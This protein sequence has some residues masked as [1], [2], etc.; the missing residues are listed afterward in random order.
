MAS[1]DEEMEAERIASY[2][3]QTQL[4]RIADREVRLKELEKDERK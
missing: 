3:R 4:K 2:Q 1:T